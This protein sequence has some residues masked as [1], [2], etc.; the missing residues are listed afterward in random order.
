MFSRLAGTCRS[1]KSVAQAPVETDMRQTALCKTRTL[2][3]LQPLKRMKSDF[4]NSLS[5]PPYSYYIKYDAW[6]VK[7]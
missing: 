1:G 6:V 2:M 5:C 3:V 7:T 4:Q